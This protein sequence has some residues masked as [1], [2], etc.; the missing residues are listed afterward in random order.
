MRGVLV[1]KRAA[2]LATLALA[3]LVLVPA[4]SAA[5]RTTDA[6]LREVGTGCEP[7]GLPNS[8]AL[9]NGS[10][11]LSV[12]LAGTVVLSVGDGNVTLKGRANR[13]CKRKRIK[14]RDG[15]I[16]WR[17]V[18]SKRAKPILPRMAPRK[19][20]GYKIFSGER[21]FFY[22][23][24]GAWRIS[25]RGSGISLSAVGEGSGGVKSRAGGGSG[26]LISIGGQIY[27]EWPHRWT[28]FEFGRDAKKDDEK[29]DT[30][31][32]DSNSNVTIRNAP[33]ASADSSVGEDVAPAREQSPVLM[34]P[35]ADTASPR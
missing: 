31:R 11:R 12:K 4:A 24:A 15:T 21:M 35:A 32:R 8:L 30:A 13:A 27:D 28:R 34:T 20:R 22:L 5:N 2:G 3:A 26:G 16:V 18:C 1:F 6:Q 17:R 7:N 19:A 33:G 23:P 9:C 14:R 25:V 29:T 10:G